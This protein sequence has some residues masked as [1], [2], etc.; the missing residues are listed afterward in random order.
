M[1]HS[2]AT[3]VFMWNAIIYSDFFFFFFVLIMLIAA[4]SIHSIWFR[5]KQLTIAL[6]L[7]NKFFPHFISIFLLLSIVPFSFELRGETRS[8]F[9]RVNSTRK[10]IDFDL[11]QIDL[12]FQ[13]RLRE[14]GQKNRKINVFVHHNTKISEK[15]HKFLEKLFRSHLNSSLWWTDSLRTKICSFAYE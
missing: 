3:Q 9:G 11:H 14:K 12:T 13:K 7:A 10:M 1:R 2:K 15:S 6:K 8:A 4:I 5:N